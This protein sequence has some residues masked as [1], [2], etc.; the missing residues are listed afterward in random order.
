MKNFFFM[1]LALCI[2][3]SCTSNGYQ[4]T[5]RGVVVTLNPQT[6]AMRAKC[7]LR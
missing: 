2:L 1:L 7:V 4:V 3:A 5:D 6:E